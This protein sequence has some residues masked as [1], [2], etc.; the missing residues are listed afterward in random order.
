MYINLTKS[1]DQEFDIDAETHISNIKAVTSDDESFY[2]LANKANDK[3]GYYLLKLNQQDPLD[4]SF[5]IHWANK[6]DIG[7]GDL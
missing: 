3:L 6:L 2:I 1:K 4:Y 5:L 7:D